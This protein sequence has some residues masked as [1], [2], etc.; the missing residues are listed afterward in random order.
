MLC[1]LPYRFI[2]FYIL[3]IMPLHYNQTL[4]HSNAFICIFSSEVCLHHGQFSSDSRLPHTRL[5]QGLE[6]LPTGSALP[7]S[8]VRDSPV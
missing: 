7:G 1:H 5:L 6:G 4:C 8:E 3:E 2:Y